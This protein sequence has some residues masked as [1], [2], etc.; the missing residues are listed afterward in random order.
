ML[1]YL[2]PGLFLAAIVIAGCGGGGGGSS[3]PAT[4]APTT[5]PSGTTVP[6]QPSPQVVTLTGA[7][8]TLQFTLPGIT[9]G[10]GTVAAA[11][12]AAAPTGVPTPSAKKRNTVGSNT[13]LVYLTV[14][15]SATITFASVP[16]FSYTLPSGTSIAAG[17]LTYIAFYDTSHPTNGWN[18]VL[19]PGT[20]SGQSIAFPSVAQSVSL[21][22]GVTYVFALIETT[23]TITTPSPQPSSSA[24]PAY[25]ANYSTPVPNV[26]SSPQPVYFTDNS[27]T[28]GQVVFY[29]VS[30]A[31]PAGGNQHQYLGTD[32]TMHNFTSGAT[33]PPIPL[34][35]FPGSSNGGHGLTFQLPPPSNA[36]Q[37]E[38]LYIAYATPAASG[39]PDPLTFIG[40]DSTGGYGGPADDWHSTS[41]VGTPYDYIEYTLPNGITDT[42]QVN[43]VGLPMEVTQGT[44]S[45]GFASSAAYASLFSGI[46][47]DTTYKSLAYSG[48]LG[49]KSL[50]QGILSPGDGQDWGFPQDWWYNS[51]FNTSYAALGQGYVGYILQQYQATP[52]LYTLNGTSQSGNY[53]ASSDGSANILF[54]YVNTGTSCASLSGSPAYTM[55]VS[56]T[57]EGANGTVVSGVCMS[58]L[59]QLPFGPGAPFTDLNE[60]YLWKALAIDI[61]RGVALQSGTHPIGSWNLNPS[62]PVPFSSYFKDPVYNKYAYLV[63][64]N[65]INNLSYALAYDEPAGQASTF[66]ANPSVP[67]QITIWNIPSYSSPQ[68]TATATPLACP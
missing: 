28:G 32:G 2:A 67:L 18:A 41:Y 40:N 20:V 17:S 44:T 15:P 60:F 37:S 6:V 55:P 14:T 25:C 51:N 21:T 63:H 23:S 43:R 26:N 62:P 9:S 64:Q 36:N 66:T 34:A 22:G 12:Q 49:G 13:T 19:G 54:Y 50:L 39:P 27:G 58:A 4:A 5:A 38:N 45:I 47:A 24:L 65:M 46:T 59:F 35:C 3:T 53:C 16:S 11:L 56:T 7:G 10:S 48:T 57:I 33:A 61:N 42:T 8:Y 1:R 68:P 30:G 52:Q 29:V 31:P